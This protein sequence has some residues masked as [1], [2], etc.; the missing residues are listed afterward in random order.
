MPALHFLVVGDGSSDRVLGRVIE[1]AI[2]QVAPNESFAPPVFRARSPISEPLA[3]FV[4]KMQAEY[5]PDLLFVHRD[6]ERDSVEKRKAE[7]PDEP[8]VVPV[9]PVRM[10]EA[11]LLISERA[12]RKAAGNPNG[13]A[14]LSMPALANVERLP[15][16]KL[17]LSNLLKTAS[18]R[19]GRRLDQ[20]DRAAAIQRVADYIDDFSAL[21][22]LTAFQAF[23]R[24][25]VTAWAAL[26]R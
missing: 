19:H 4:E 9:I 11:W 16:P 14:H 8:R 20:F 6:A 17:L 18:G 12:I 25:L 23:E 26:Q 1:W 7:I 10:T 13:D 21:R 2:R 3:A 15:N 22:A 24:A 5:R